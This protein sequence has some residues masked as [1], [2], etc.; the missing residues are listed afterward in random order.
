MQQFVV[1]VVASAIVVA[2]STRKENG[3]FKHLEVSSLSDATNTSSDESGYAQTMD[4]HLQN[5][6]Q[7][8]K[9]MSVGYAKIQVDPIVKHCIG[10]IAQ[11]GLKRSRECRR[12]LNAA[13]A[14]CR[15]Q[16]SHGGGGGPQGEQV[17]CLQML[18]A[19]TIVRDT[20]TLLHKR[21]RQDE[22][23]DDLLS[24]VKRRRGECNAGELFGQVPGNSLESKCFDASKE[25]NTQPLPLRLFESENTI[26]SD[27]QNIEIGDLLVQVYTIPIGQ[28]DCNI[29]TCNGGKNAIL[30][31]CGS[32]GGNNFRKKN[33]KYNLIHSPFD[34]AESI[35][36]LISHGHADHHNMIRKVLNPNVVTIPPKDKVTVILGGKEQ[37]YSKALKTWIKKIAAKV[38]ILTSRK[39]ENLCSNANIWFDLMPGNMNSRNANE[40]GMLMK[41]HCK[42]CQSSLLFTGDM[43]GPTAKEFGTT[44]D[45]VT[46]NFLR[47]THYKMAHHGA[48]TLANE[49]EWLTAIMPIEVHIS[50]KYD[51]RYHH[52]R[53]EAMNRLMKSCKLGVTSGTQI[54]QP[55]DLTCFGE[56]VEKYKAYEKRV[57]HR[58]FSTAPQKDELCLIVMSFKV[59]QEAA[60]DY[61]CS[62]RWAI[63]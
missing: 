10:L 33:K 18:A 32:R 54:A 47:A 31:D 46:K 44:T 4:Y 35:S 40:R 52:P 53:C 61:Y 37:D 2:A 25:S 56:K 63:L 1:Y 23:C 45:T 60:T 38:E 42:T 14:Y 22:E 62:S 49:K 57:Y 12:F 24:Q 17:L 48:A 43:E 19:V 30:F 3:G 21:N 28:G 5:L 59:S 8:G 6:L 13:I 41:L 51:G 50:H 26:S 58:V 39:R 11:N 27:A 15:E 55:H 20:C 34:N 7:V 16:L 9:E 36:I 29:I